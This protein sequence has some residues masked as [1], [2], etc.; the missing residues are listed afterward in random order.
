MKK[1]DKFVD[2][3]LSIISIALYLSLILVVAIQIIVR[4]TPMTTPWSDEISR[5]VFVYMIC[6]AGGLSLK[7]N[8][9]ADVDLVFGHFPYGVKKFVYI[10]NQLLILAFNLILIV[11]G[12]KFGKVGILS[13][14]PVTKIP[15][16]IMF[17]SICV[18]GIFAT[19]YSIY[20]IYSFFVDDEKTIASYEAG[21]FEI[22][23]EKTMQAQDK[24]DIL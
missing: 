12:Y 4:F 7:H 9:Y 21:E 16:S 17:F 15:M 14:S 5:Y 2:K 3:F 11:S 19:F 6:L 18:L 10:L 8:A 13:V 1:V 24:P 20:N 22:E 23:L